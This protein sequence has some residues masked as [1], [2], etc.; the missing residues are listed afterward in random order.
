MLIPLEWI[1]LKEGRLPKGL[2]HQRQ[3]TEREGFSLVHMSTRHDVI[4][5]E[6]KKKWDRRHGE[7]AG[8]FELQNIIQ[9]VTCMSFSHHLFT[10]PWKSLQISNTS[11]QIDFLMSPGPTHS[12]PT[13]FQ[14]L[15]ALDCHSMF[16]RLQISLKRKRC[17]SDWKQS[18]CLSNSIFSKNNE[19]TPTRFQPVQIKTDFSKQ[20][21]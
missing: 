7:R 14:L 1:V 20:S 5:L 21:L 9:A 19:T 18:P 16:Q 17:V 4:L 8:K 3:A 2:D 12:Q 11:L 10:A 15:S 13:L 6:Y